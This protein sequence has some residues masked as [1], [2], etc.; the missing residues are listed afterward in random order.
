MTGFLRTLVLTIGLLCHGQSGATGLLSELDASS[1]ATTLGSFHAETQRVEALY[2]TYST[3]P[4]T[5]KQFAMA[6]ALQ[7]IGARLFDLGEIPP[8]MRVKSGNAVVGYLADILLRLPEI[9]PESVPGGSGAQGGDL[10]PYWTIPGTEI[11]MVRLGEG[12]RSGDYVFS[13]ATVARLPQIHAQAKGLPALRPSA[14]GDWATVQQRVVGPWLMRL[15]L[16]RLPASLQ[17]TMLGTPI[18]KVLFAGFIAATIVVVVLR[19]RSLVGRWTRTGSA[20]RRYALRLTVPVLLGV[21]VVLGHGFIAWQV[22]PSS[23]IARAETLVATL[24]LYVA[25]AWAAWCACWLIA[26]AIIASPTF[27]EDTFDAHLLRIVARVGSLVAAGGILL[28][29]ANDIGVPGVGL[30]AGVSIG[31]IALALAAQSTVENLLGGVTIFA[32]RPFR[33]GDQIR[34]GT[35]SGTVESIGPRS[36]RIRGADGTLTSVPNADLAKTQ[37]VNVSARP[38]CVFQHKVGLPSG[39]SSARIEALLAELRRRVAAHPLVETAFG[40]PRVRLVGLGTGERNIEVEVFARILTTATPEFLEA[41]EALLLDILRG[42]E[43]CG[44]DLADP[45]AAGQARA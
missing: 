39:L 32:D 23:E 37:L 2:E 45:A 33:V 26:E 7:R 38:N 29:G 12:P 43:A 5:A 15:P 28:Y 13:A 18:W 40:L 44:V 17:A 8:A 27:P 20:W 31:G 14:I 30:L 6:D 3:A 16:E 11:R 4:T 10:P 34:F 25:A 36:T 21:L 42:A 35:G 22:V 19:W 1:P 9:P 41:Q 24:A